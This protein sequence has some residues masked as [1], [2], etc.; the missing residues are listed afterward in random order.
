MTQP[1][2][3]ES[4]QNRLIDILLGA[5]VGGLSVFAAMLLR[6]RSQQPA[7]ERSVDEL[8]D[9]LAEQA[10]TEWHADSSIARPYAAFREELIAEGLLEDNRDAA[11]HD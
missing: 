1:T 7:Y 5:L 8:E 4:P 6:E 2:R 3:V 10:Y 9:F 11:V